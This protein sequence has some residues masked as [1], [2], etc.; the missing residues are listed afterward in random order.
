MS[1]DELKLVKEKTLAHISKGLTSREESID[2]IRGAIEKMA[3]R[4]NS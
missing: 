1:E 4:E 2:K 3:K